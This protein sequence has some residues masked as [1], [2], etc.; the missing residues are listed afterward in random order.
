M[1]KIKAVI[2]AGGKGTRLRPLTC[3]IPKPMVPIFDRPVMEYTLKLLKK[4]YIYDVGVTLAYLPQVIM[5]YFGEGKDYEL[6]VQYFIEK[7]ALGTG[8]SVRNTGDFLDGTFIVISG[9]SLT[10]LDLGKAVEFHKSKKSKATLVLKKEPVPIEYGVIIT[11]ADGRIV[12]FLEKPSWGEVFSDTVNTGIYILEPEVLEYYPKGENFDFSKDLFPK[13]LEDNIPMY[14]YIT[15]DYWCDIGDLTSYR[16]THFDVLDGKLKLDLEAKEI[17]KGVWMGSGTFISSNAK[18]I[19]PV[20]VGSGSI[21]DGGAIIDSYSV[22]SRNCRIGENSRVKRSILWKNSEIG[23]G[24]GISG[25][26]LCS[27]TIVKNRVNI[28]E[29]TVIG[30]DTI[31]LDGSLIKPDIKIWPEKKV[32]ENT[33]VTQ[34]IIWGTKASKNIFGVR[35][36][37]GILNQELSPEFCSRLGSAYAA[38]MSGNAALVVSSDN[39]PQSFIVKSSIVSGILSEGSQSIVLDKSITPMA[40][41]GIRYHKAVGGIHIYTSHRKPYR[42]YIEFFDNKGVNVARNMERSI[43]NLLNRDDYDRCK[44]ED[45]KSSMRMENFHE[46]YIRQGVEIIS[47]TDEIRRKNFKVILAS[48]SENA[49]AIAYKYLQY[50]GCNVSLVW[51]ENEARNIAKQ[52]LNIKADLGIIIGENGENLILIDEKGKI[53][54]DEEYFL[55]AEIIA[56]KGYNAAKL[57]F[58]YAFPTAAEEIANDYGVQILRTSSNISNIIGE[59]LQSQDK[60]YWPPAQFVLNHDAIWALG[61][62]LEYIAKEN[63][64]LSEIAEQIPKFYYT[65]SEIACDWKDKGRV[66]REIAVKR[67]GHELELLEGVKI[68]DHRGWA[69]LLPD[70]EKPIFNVYTQ[71]FSQEMA[72]ELSADLTNRIADLLKNKKN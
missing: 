46:I 41:F 24:N 48:Q 61:Y 13:L 17:T 15:E 4:H 66:I 2:M 64:R 27:N 43:E 25:A 62:I 29:N 16:Q 18:L 22:I 47:K 35:G 28:L 71:G 7:T 34:N 60:A 56:I 32:Y 38:S 59:M 55:M 72:K 33:I 70:N 68:K 44:V 54:K 53:I 21:I 12:R 45:I 6:N 63:L 26:V 30:Q 37:S 51:V 5:D 20:Y 65:K 10:D 36:I 39:N 52:L 11:A 1:V 67:N 8:G 31:L 19:P 49:A 9:D 40:R 14:G 3:G 57:V 23:D 42:T 58:P 50:L 69:L